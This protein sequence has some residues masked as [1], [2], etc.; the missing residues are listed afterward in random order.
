MLMVQ[1]QHAGVSIQQLKLLTAVILVKSCVAE[2]ISYN[3]LFG[4]GTVFLHR[5]I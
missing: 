2:C 3:L 1:L 4:T 5:R